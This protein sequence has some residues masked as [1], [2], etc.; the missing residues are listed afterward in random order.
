MAKF[1]M[2]GPL[3]A[4]SFVLLFA[5]LSLV[6][7]MLSL[8]SNAAIGL[9]SLRL[10]WQRGLSI[11]IPSAAIL[12]GISLIAGAEPFNGFVL[13]L[14]VWLPIIGLAT[15]LSKTVAWQWVLSSL[16]AL[17]VLGVGGFHLM[18]ESPISFWQAQPEWQAFVTLLGEMQMLPAELEATTRQ[19]ILDGMAQI[20]MGSLVLTANV[21]LVLSLIIARFWQAQLYNPS[22]FRQEWLG[23]KV[24]QVPAIIL[25]GL[26]GVALVGGFA[27]AIDMVLAGL[28]VFIFQGLAMLHALAH[29]NQWHNVWLIGIYVLLVALTVHVAILLG[30]LGII[31][32]FADFRKYF[33]ADRN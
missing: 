3:Q 22:G 33:K 27:W 20:L 30:T 2:A 6:L 15:I 7:P 8:L 32:S 16:F 9:V 26:I 19:Q 25:L 31:D 1:I 23:L 5:V 29:S 17:S 13:S 4:I 21:L 18:V 14:V 24:G 10:G 28:A 11:A 12:A